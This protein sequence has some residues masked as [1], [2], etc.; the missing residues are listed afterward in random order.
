MKL[1]HGC[2]VTADIDGLCAFY[3]DVL[4]LEATRFGDD[5]AEFTLDGATL[6]LCGR[7]TMDGIIPGEMRE[8]ANSSLQLEF[9]VGDVDKEYARLVELGIRDVKKPTDYPWGNRHFYCKDPDGNILSFY[10]PL[11]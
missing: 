4:G 11:G 2:I 8:R 3:R 10:T 1:T 9:Q 5:Y 7:S 6:A